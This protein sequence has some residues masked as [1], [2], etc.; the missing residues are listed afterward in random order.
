MVIASQGSNRC[1]F[2]SLFKLLRY[3]IRY[4][5]TKSKHFLNQTF[6]DKLDINVSACLSH[7]AQFV[8]INFNQ[9]TFY[10]AKSWICFEELFQRCCIYQLY[11]SKNWTIG[12]STCW[13]DNRENT[14]GHRSVRKITLASIYKKK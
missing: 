12:Q 1:P 9:T 10:L 6:S 14:S 5:D 11:R 8:Q 4:K 2:F 7:C 13:F 3:W